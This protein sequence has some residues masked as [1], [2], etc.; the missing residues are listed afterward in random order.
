[1][2]DLIH[3]SDLVYGLLLLAMRWWSA[4]LHSDPRLLLWDSR[5]AVLGALRGHMNSTMKHRLLVLT[6]HGQVAILLVKGLCLLILKYHLI[7]GVE[8][9]ISTCTHHIV[10]IAAISW[11]LRPQQLPDRW[12]YS[13]Y[14]NGRRLVIKVFGD[15]GDISCSLRRL[16]W[17]DPLAIAL[18]DIQLDRQI[19]LELV[20]RATWHICLV[21]DKHRP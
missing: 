16:D 21:I 18:I 10:V 12:R 13:A 17:H 7:E 19:V 9:F 5:H 15:R 6:T 2:Q 4:V 11:R 1:M 3:G 14:D 20:L 8:M